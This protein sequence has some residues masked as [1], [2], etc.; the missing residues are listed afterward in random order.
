MILKINKYIFL[1]N[2][3][4]IAICGFLCY[5]IFPVPPI[6]WR[7][8]FLV[9]AVIVIYYNI[10]KFSTIEKTILL[11]WMLNI[12][13]YFLSY[14]WVDSPSTTQIGNISVTLLS[15][16]LF[17][18][19]A[20]K[21][22]LTDKFYLIAVVLIIIAAFVY[23]N[24]MR[25]NMLAK[26]IY[27]KDSITN[28]A[29]TVFLYI[30]TFTLILKNRYVSYAIILICVYFIL[31][32]AKRGNIVC[33]VPVLVCVMFNTFRNKNIKKFEKIIFVIF[34]LFALSW[35]VNQFVKNEYLIERIE[36]TQEGNSSGR[37]VIY[38]KAWEIF[39]NSDNIINIVFGHGFDATI[40]HPSLKIHAHN[41]WLEIL[42]NYGI[43]GFFVYF[44]IFIALFKLIMNEK[45][46]D[47][48]SLLI[49][50]TSI[51]FL[52]SIFSMGFTDDTIFIL[53]LSFAYAFR[54]NQY[55]Y[56]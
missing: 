28:N 16:P 36:Q 2:I 26:Y 55:K 31:D 15:F 27:E 19:L 53:A 44:S 1:R 11:F 7:L 12:F 40:N 41:D 37:D 52:K 47:K 14:L 21:N 18:T 3:A 9:P 22:I 54:N 48:K 46:I 56:E 5:S 32:G 35:G 20:K 17:I 4:L 8:L 10:N 45:E 42:V 33:S 51:W 39:S 43:L 29:T 49:S 30:L 50:V 6:T 24:T 34:F 25:V 38:T 13:Y 23:Y